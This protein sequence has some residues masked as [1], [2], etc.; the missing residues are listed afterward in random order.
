MRTPNLQYLYLQ[1]PVTL[2]VIICIIC[3]LPWLGLGNMFESYQA[4]YTDHINIVESM[5]T[6][7]NWTI[8]YLKDGSIDFP[9]F[10]WLTILF[11]MPQ[12][13]VS[14]LTFHITGAISFI[15]L[16]TSILI[17]YGRRIKFHQAFIATLLLLTCLG[18]QKIA[19]EIGNELLFSTLILIAMIQMYRWEESGELKGL[20]ISIPILLSCAALTQGLSGIFIPLLIFGSYLYSLKKYPIRII[21]KC[22]IYIFIASI[23]IPSLWYISVWKSSPE[24]FYSTLFYSNWWTTLNIANLFKYVLFG[25]MPWTIFFIFS[26]FGLKKKDFISIGSNCSAYFASL[27]N[28]HRFSLVSFIGFF[29]SYLL[30]PE[31]HIGFIGLFI[32]FISL[33]LSQY[34]LYITEYRTKCTRLFAL[35]LAIAMTLCITTVILTVFGVVS[36]VKILAY[37]ENKWAISYIQNAQIFFSQPTVPVIMLIVCTI[38]SLL[39]VYYQ[40]F[41]NINIKMLYSTIALMFFSNLLFCRMLL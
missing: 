5:L 26:L 23:F 1:K 24:L 35:V 31:K 20:P 15:A 41:R 36:P 7:G 11:S 17:F 38:L 22:N 33:F 30:L 13:F 6:S 34:A 10:Y 39:I 25:F 4:T 18:L 19:I 3:V 40:M 2:I 16:M 28:V 21:L 8:P 9:L 37:T 14:S 29:V 12:G 27:C 32:T